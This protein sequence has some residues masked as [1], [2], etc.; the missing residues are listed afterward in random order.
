MSNGRGD[1]VFKGIEG[2][3]AWL[4]WT[5]VFV[6]A[7]SVFDV[8]ANLLG[9]SAV[10]VFII[11]SGFVITHL[12]IEKREQYPVF[13]WRRFLRLYPAYFVAL[14]LAVLTEPM[15]FKAVLDNPKMPASMV[16]YFIREKEQFDSNFTPHL[17]AHLSL[18]HGAIPNTVLRN[19][20][21]MFLQSAW[22]LSLEWQF[23]L[24]APLWIWALQH[25]PIAGVAVAL[26]AAVIYKLFLWTGFYN[27]SFLPG[28]VL[29][30]LLGIA[31]RFGINLLPRVEK[32]PF[33]VVLGCLGLAVMDKRFLALSA[34]IAMVGYLVQ[35]QMWSVLDSRIARAAG[36]RSYAVYLVHIP[37]IGAALY[38]C[39]IYQLSG[40]AMMAVVGTITILGTLAA[41]E[42]IHRFVELPA[43]EWGKSFGGPRPALETVPLIVE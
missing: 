22:S 14:A 35:P 33:A 36:A 38:M 5:V 39:M 26:F 20:Q 7:I 15:I 17:L 6:H 32:Y 28:A 27:P 34:W 43:I 21:Y 11:I 23:Y 42:L 8:E 19:S 41:S 16:E 3:R 2:L 37:F 31:T 4:A 40:V 13:I 1:I 30:F 10:L 9:D 29:W 25:K 24:I 12:L 18:L